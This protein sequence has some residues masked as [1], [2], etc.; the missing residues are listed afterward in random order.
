MF[1]MYVVQQIKVCL[2]RLKSLIWGLF[3]SKTEHQRC[4]VSQRINGIAPS[5][6]VGYIPVPNQKL[7][8]RQLLRLELFVQTK[9]DQVVPSD[10]FSW[11]TK[12]VPAVAG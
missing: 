7:L 5:F 10:L 6:L 1:T 8:F 11:E 4:S 12:A 2:K 9:H 3:R